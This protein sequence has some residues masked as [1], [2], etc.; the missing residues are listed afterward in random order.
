MEIIASPEFETLMKSDYHPD[1]T[2]GDAREA[3]SYLLDY[4][5][6]VKK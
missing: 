3:V 5:D 2:L 4:C 6:E 1:V